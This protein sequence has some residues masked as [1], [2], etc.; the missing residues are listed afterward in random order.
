MDSLLDRFCRYVKIESGAVEGTSNYPSSPGQ[1]E[2]GKLLKG[3]LE[4]L[5]IKDVSMDE[6][7]IVMGTIPGNMPDAPVIA[8]IAHVDTSP[9]FTGRNV[10]PV[11]HENYDGK[12][13]VL[14]GCP[15]SGGSAAGARGK[16]PQAADRR[17]PSAAAVCWTA[18]GLNGCQLPL[19]SHPSG[20][21]PT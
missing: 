12:D 21:F 20:L 2:M 14:P 1:L 5:G 11:V 10:K 4:A 3:E 16:L 17:R 15:T 19:R 13:I 8:W 9:E 6:Y 7:G 18:P